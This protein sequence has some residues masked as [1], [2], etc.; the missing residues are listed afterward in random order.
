MKIVASIITLLVVFSSNAQYSYYFAEPLP[1]AENK[2]DVVKEKYFGRYATKDGTITYSFDSKGMTL[3]STTISAISKEKVRESSQYSVRNGYIFGVEKN[4]SV[5]CILEEGFYH[6]AVRNYDAFVGATSKN[7]LTA[8]ATPGEYVL[9]VYD[10][11][12]YVPQLLRFNG[13]K[14]EVSHFDYSGEEPGEFSY[15]TEQEELALD[16]IKLIILKP[17]ASDFDRIASQ[18]LMEDMTLKK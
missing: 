1:S 9:N 2:V 5:P 13:K 10:N 17:E 4:D 15:I 18:A 14:L 6:F 3:I 12:K 11:G 8:T 16:G 7:I